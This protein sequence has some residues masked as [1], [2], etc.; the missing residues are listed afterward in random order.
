MY[1]ECS[2]AKSGNS[3][4]VNQDSISFHSSYACLGNTKLYLESF[5]KKETVIEIVLSTVILGVLGFLSTKIMDIHGTLSGVDARVTSTSERVERIASAL[6]DI[7]VRVAHEELSR[8]IRTMVVTTLPT[9]ADAQGVYVAFVNVVDGETSDVWTI[10]V[11]MK[12]GKDK[13][14]IASIAWA[15]ASRSDEYASFATM[16]RYAKTASID[17]TLPSYV[18]PASSFILTSTS[19][20]E[21][22]KEVSSFAPS[23]QKNSASIEVNTWKDVSRVLNERRDDL[24]PKN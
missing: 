10:P 1:P 8:P 17:A 9:K 24:S 16:Q 21:Y 5:V 18:D 19:A 6:P 13:D 3:Q 23:A 22:L 15:G 14:A 4:N 20:E 7:G 2:I 11:R 12:S